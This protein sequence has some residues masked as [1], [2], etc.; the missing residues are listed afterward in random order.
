MLWQQ[1]DGE[2]QVKPLQGRLFRLVE[3]QTRVATLEYVDSLEEQALLEELLE[4]VKPAYRD[5]QD[6]LH[7]L[8][9]SPFRYPPLPW[10]SRFGR[11]HEPGLFYAGGSVHTTLA[12]A[13]YYRLL[14]WYSMNGP[15]PK[16]RIHTEHTLFSARYRTRRGVQLHKPPFSRFREELSHP[17]D[18]AACQQLGTAMRE[19]GVEVFQ[20]L[21]ARDRGSGYCVALF[22]PAGFHVRQP[23]AIS[24]WQCELTADSATFRLTAS[25]SLTRFPLADF[26]CDGQLPLPA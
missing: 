13:A 25:N 23:E 19:A 12:E 2:Q 10:G 1:L 3:S 18:Y 5:D 21:S 4:T 11:P 6:Q 9:R 26:L 22:S 14:F 7:Y 8:L 17:S 20:Y 16:D 24:L 15:T